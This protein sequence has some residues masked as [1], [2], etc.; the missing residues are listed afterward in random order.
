MRIHELGDG[1]YIEEDKFTDDGEIGLTFE[2]NKRRRYW[3]D[4]SHR[5]LYLA[6]GP[7]V[8]HPDS[9]DAADIRAERKSCL[10]ELTT[11]KEKLCSTPMN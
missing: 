9:P 8:P 6:I 2:L 7:T 3:F 10:D 11:L 4:K 1:Y 5:M